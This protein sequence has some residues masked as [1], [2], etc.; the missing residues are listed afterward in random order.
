MSGWASHIEPPKGHPT[1]RSMH[2]ILEA[3]NHHLCMPRSHV[4]LH[5][6]LRS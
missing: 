3:V 5:Y 1:R 4:A 6:S 2:S